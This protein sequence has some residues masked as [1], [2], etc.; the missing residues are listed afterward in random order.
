MWTA[1]WVSMLKTTLQQIDKHKAKC[2]KQLKIIEIIKTSNLGMEKKIK[3]EKQELKNMSSSYT[4]TMGFGITTSIGV[5][6][7]MLV[8]FLQ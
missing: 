6:N 2:I 4:S 1:N 5:L 7:D 3:E 8:E